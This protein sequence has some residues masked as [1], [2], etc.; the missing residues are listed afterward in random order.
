MMMIGPQELRIRNKMK[1]QNLKPRVI[2]RK[3]E[4]GEVEFR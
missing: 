1:W 3:R 2:N 4:A